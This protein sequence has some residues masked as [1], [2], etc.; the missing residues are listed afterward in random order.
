MFDPRMMPSARMAYVVRRIPTKVTRR[1]CHWVP[2]KSG[3]GG[4]LVFKDVEVEGGFMVYFPKG[5][6]IRLTAK[7]LTHYGLTERRGNF[8]SMSGLTP[9]DEMMM[10]EDRSLMQTHMENIE[11]M[12]IR[13]A[14]KRTGPLLMPEQMTGAVKPP[15]TEKHVEA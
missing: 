2:N 15:G 14:T 8:V 6:A 5:H 4:E 11:N 10:V 13:L 7:Q 1:K 3:K 12:T 9:Q